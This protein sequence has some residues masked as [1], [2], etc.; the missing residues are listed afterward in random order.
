MTLEIIPS[1]NLKDMVLGE[2]SS[3]AVNINEELGSNTVNLI[4]YDI[5]NNIGDSV[6]SVFGGGH[7]HENGII[8]F[9][10]KGASIG[11]YMIRFII[12]CNE[13]LPDGVTPEE[14]Y[15]LLYVDINET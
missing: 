10:V 11:T 7:I 4:S 9:G 14:F 5:I 12:T 13:F 2:E 6:L 3:Y 8:S 1:D 15:V